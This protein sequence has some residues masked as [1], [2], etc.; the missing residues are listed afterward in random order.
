MGIKKE[1]KEIILRN[2]KQPN[3]FA[4]AIYKLSPIGKKL[5]SYSVYRFCGDRAGRIIFSYSEFCHDLNMSVGGNTYELVKEAVNEIFDLRIILVE[6]KR[7]YSIL[8]VY[9]KISMEETKV[10]FCFEEKIKTLI[11]LYERENFT[12]LSLSKIGT[13]KSFYSIRFYEIALSWRGKIG[14]IKNNRN[15]WFFDYEFEDLKKLFVAE[16]VR[17]NNFVRDCIKKPL[18]EINEKI[19]DIEMTTEI[20]A[21]EPNG[22]TP[23]IIRFWCIDTKQKLIE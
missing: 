11:K 10:V 17:N 18:N 2:L 9:S 5:F 22:K 21:Y 3:S 19:D 7:K 16:N 6:E 13:L 4:R 20:K 12:I 23:K 14:A 8:H 1:K 15:A